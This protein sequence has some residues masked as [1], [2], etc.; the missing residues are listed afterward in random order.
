[1]S[2]LVL[3][4]HPDDAELAAGGTIAALHDQGIRIVVACFTTSE[5]SHARRARRR[6]AAA[7]AAAVLGHHLEWIE[8]GDHDQVEE[9]P[10]SQLVALVDALVDRWD[11]SAIVTHTEAD[12]HADHVRVARAAI[13][14]SRRHPHRTLLQFAPSDYRTPAYTA[15]SPTTYVE[16]SQAHLERKLR[17]LAAYGAADLSVRPPDL[18]AVELV[19]RA[20]GLE[21]GTAL[22]E[23]FRHVRQLVVMCD[24]HQWNAGH[25]FGNPQLQG[26]N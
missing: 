19:A 15:F 9:I 14:S 23:P 5:T 7:D 20:R 1:M 2:V 10:D 13:A 4:A 16:I 11:P 3:A 8:R 24:P 22:A 17:A 12:S 18:D 6:R 21:V 26:G 25:P